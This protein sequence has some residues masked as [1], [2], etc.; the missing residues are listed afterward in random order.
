MKIRG[1]DIFLVMCSDKKHHQKDKKVE[2]SLCENTAWISGF[3]S[4]RADNLV[5]GKF[6]GHP[7]KGKIKYV[8]SFCVQQMLSKTIDMFL[9]VR[10]LSKEKRTELMDKIIAKSDIKKE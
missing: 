1:K 9:K 4:Y 7:K 10:D 8:C 3:G 2:C 5:K 6:V